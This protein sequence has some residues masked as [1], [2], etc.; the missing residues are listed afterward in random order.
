MIGA[1]CRFIMQDVG[2]EAEGVR[3]KRHVRSD[4][5]LAVSIKHKHCNARIARELRVNQKQPIVIVNE[6]QSVIPT[7]RSKN[8]DHH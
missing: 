6:I 2:G 4:L 8:V 3:T 5:V 1:Q 7:C